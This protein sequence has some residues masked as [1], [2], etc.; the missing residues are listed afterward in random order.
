MDKTTFVTFFS[1]VLFSIG[2]GIS[3]MTQP[4]K[5]IG[6]LDVFGSGGREGGRS[7]V[8]DVEGPPRTDPL[9]RTLP[10][11]RLPPDQDATMN[12]IELKLKLPSSL[13]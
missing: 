10:P 2:L 1:G 8:S 7:K 6:F 9:R 13:P 3:G 11:R 12:F 4:Q 5:V